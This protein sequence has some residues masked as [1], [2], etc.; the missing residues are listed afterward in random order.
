MKLRRVLFSIAL[1]LQ[2]VQSV[3]ALEF[4]A[5]AGIGVNYTDNSLKVADDEESD[6]ETR[7]DGGFVL[8]HDGQS[9]LIDID[10]RAAY[11]EYDRDTQSDSTQVDGDASVQYQQ[12]DE[13]LFW[14]ISNSVRS[15]I[16]DKRLQ[17][18][19]DNREN[20]SITTFSP[21]LR[22]PITRVD[23][24]NTV[25]SYSRTD[26]EDNSQQESERLGGT[27][28][29]LHRFSQV[30]SL[31]LTGGYFDVNFDNSISDYEYYIARLSY[32]STLSKLSYTLV[33]GYNEV[34]REVFEDTDGP[35]LN[36][37]FVYKSGFSQWELNL[38]QELTDTS[39]GNNNGDISGLDDSS[40]TDGPVDVYEVYTGELA[41]STEVLCGVCI[42]RLSVLA[43]KEDY[44]ILPDDNE[45]IGA[46]VR[47][48]YRL[49]TLSSI[50]AA[51]AYADYSFTG[52]NPRVDYDLQRYEL[53][54]RR[55]MT[56]NF[57]VRL[58]T[59]FEKRESDVSFSE[60]EEIRGGVSVN[61][62][63]R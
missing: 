18:T 53:F 22:L 36:A 62:E 52:N 35:Y 42:L 11:I 6:Y 3:H 33:V 60:Y 46:R 9:W 61:Y 8:D 5:D 31:D 50:G 38:L 23:S 44:E 29:W 55:S 10:Y 63:F 1:L 2:L 39:R 37:N 58:F 28:S 24:L 32:A 43:S 16:T 25:A 51:I 12:I 13:V 30:D 49:S 17:D 15:V 26:Y 54:F 56:R 59:S 7:L 40:S 34:Q 45:E 48:D 57:S 20:R 21:E 27:V 41:Y 47:F 19:S 14:N 4:S